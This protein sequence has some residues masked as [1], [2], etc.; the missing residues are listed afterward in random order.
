MTK[1]EM[2]EAIKTVMTT[3]ELPEG[4]ESG[5]PIIE[6]CDKEIE[7]LEKRAAKS[8]ERAAAKKA[9]G[10]ELM[11][12]VRLALTDDFEPISAIVE[13]VEGDDVTVSKVTYRLSALVRDGIAV[14]ESI[15][16]AS[17]DGGKSRKLMGYKL[18]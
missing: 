4:M 15:N 7:A 3:G 6:F 5:D 14:K 1:R 12:A 8:R 10:D 9:E 18:A 2:F 17:E 13:R 16:V 11:E